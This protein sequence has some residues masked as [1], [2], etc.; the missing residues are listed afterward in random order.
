M[1][2]FKLDDMYETLGRLKEAGEIDRWHTA[3]ADTKY[4]RRLARLMNGGP[5][6]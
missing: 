3:I 5:K 2:C 4:R 1:P 6:S